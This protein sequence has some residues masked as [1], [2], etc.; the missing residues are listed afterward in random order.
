MKPKSN[1]S[2]KRPW[3][4]W[5]VGGVLA[6]A[7]AFALYHF[8]RTNPD[9][10]FGYTLEGVDLGDFAFFTMMC[11]PLPDPLALILQI[12]PG[13]VAN[14]H[15]SG[16]RARCPEISLPGRP[17]RRRGHQLCDDWSAIAALTTAHAGA[18]RAFN[19]GQ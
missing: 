2:K 11:I 3:L 18:G 13:Q 10:W 19:A 8:A 14:S 7:I 15:R 17:S 16:R 6:G 9:A 5:A 12:K 1:G 4:K